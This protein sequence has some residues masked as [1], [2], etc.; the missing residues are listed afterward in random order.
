MFYFI[1]G[2]LT[3]I[4]FYKIDFEKVSYTLVQL[5]DLYS[6][7]LQKQDESLSLFMR[8]YSTTRQVMNFLFVT[9]LQKYLTYFKPH[10]ET[11]KLYEGEKVLYPL[12]I[13][14]KTK[15][16]PFASTHLQTP[17]ILNLSFERNNDL[18]S[19][20]W[21]T[22]NITSVLSVYSDMKGITPRDLGLKTLSIEVLDGIDVKKLTF[23][24]QDQIV[25]N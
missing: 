21:L 6:T 13:G 12:S 17:D 9:F 10:Q 20:K 14:N 8:H 15:Y 3:G 16:I 1:L 2:V 23:S 19:E 4:L 22:E 18:F 7:V 25:I 5:S 11:I 24:E